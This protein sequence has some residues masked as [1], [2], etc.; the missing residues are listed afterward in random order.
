M[1][2]GSH[3]QEQRFDSRIKHLDFSFTYLMSLSSP[4]DMKVQEPSPSE[5][6]KISS[7]VYK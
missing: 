2:Y 5:A 1:V 7:S 4:V 6:C 3:I